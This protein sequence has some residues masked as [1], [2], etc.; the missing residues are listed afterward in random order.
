MYNSCG[1]DP[2]FWKKD[3]QPLFCVI[4]TRKGDAP[5]STPVAR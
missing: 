2:A 5:D 3:L 1:Q 4:G